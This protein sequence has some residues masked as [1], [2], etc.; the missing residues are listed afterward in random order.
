[1]PTV[2]L[3]HWN[4]RSSRGGILRRLP[5]G[6]RVSNFGDLLGPIIA[7]RIL[8]D[9]G[10]DARTA[11][12]R[13]RLLTVGSV[14]RMARDGDTVWGT[15]ANG[16]SLDQE[17]AFADLDVR[18]VRG[19]LT[20]EFL[21]NKGIAVPEVFGDPGLLVGT[22]WSR[23]ELRGPSPERA[24]TVIPNLNDVASYDMTDQRII[25]PRSPLKNCLAAIAASKF[26]TGSSLHG[27]VLAESLGI[28]AR[29]VTSPS[30]PPF[31]Y[32]DYYLGSG[33]A[34]YTPASSVS[35]AIE[36]GGEAPVQWDPTAL[37]NAFPY[38]LWT[39]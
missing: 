32:L 22:L 17:F 15:G 4:P 30:E 31:K 5:V 21:E 27:V 20:K 3:V 28:P 8:S 25:D 1:M 35:E 6:K 33:R 10:I 29:L 19:P 2:E 26:V 12:R 37:L 14:L 23:E 11:K 13:G 7:K 16:K 18:A 34:N 36:M 9:R 38:D 24:I 39:A